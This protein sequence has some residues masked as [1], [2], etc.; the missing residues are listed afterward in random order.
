[1]QTKSIFLLVKV[2]ITAVPVFLMCWF[3]LR[4]LTANADTFI[5][6]LALSFLLLTKPIVSRFKELEYRFANKSIEANDAVFRLSLLAGFDALVAMVLFS[7]RF[8]FY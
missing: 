7:I 4:L 1:M 3:I 8:Q 2:W 6:F 5:V